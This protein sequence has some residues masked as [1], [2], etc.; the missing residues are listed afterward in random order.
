MMG[1]KI[2]LYALEYVRRGNAQ[3]QGTR[4]D[5]D[6]S[7]HWQF[8]RE[9]E[10]EGSGKFSSD[11]MT[12]SSTTTPQSAL[13]T[14]SSE[15]AGVAFIP[16]FMYDK[17]LAG[18]LCRT[19]ALAS[20][21]QFIIE[22]WL[23][24]VLPM[25]NGEQTQWL[26]RNLV[27]GCLPSNV[28]VSA[29][30]KIKRLSQTSKACH[31]GVI[32]LFFWVPTDLEG[33]AN[34]H[35]NIPWEPGGYSLFSSEKRWSTLLD[36][37][38]QLLWS[39]LLGAGA[40]RIWLVDGLVFSTG[41]GQ[42]PFQGGGDVFHPTS[43]LPSSTRFLSTTTTTSTW[44]TATSCTIMAAK[45]ILTKTEEIHMPW[46]PGKSTLTYPRKL[47]LGDKP[48]FKEGGMLGPSPVCMMV[49]YCHGLEPMG[50]AHPLELLLILSWRQRTEHPEGSDENGGGFFSH[51]GSNSPSSSCLFLCVASEFLYL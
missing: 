49:G 24:H 39:S 31:Q 16:S 10:F 50:L 33:E 28:Y 42:A 13:G 27:S 15:W 9:E 51:L 29:L 25:G 5:M 6:I 14:M 11:R 1:T 7:V 38:E 26:V 17:D 30:S 36:C 3:I 4:K 45:V 20:S 46:D 48:S 44:S 43:A 19:Y 23:T 40:F 32:A 35:W 8:L 18:C 41:S 47:R 37:Y 22:A 12:I 21:M 34:Q 2:V